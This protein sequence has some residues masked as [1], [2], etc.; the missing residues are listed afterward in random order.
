[1]PAIGASTTGGQTGYWPM[2]SVPAGGGRGG[3]TRTGS[4]TAAR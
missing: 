3:R 2:C 4:R 1:M